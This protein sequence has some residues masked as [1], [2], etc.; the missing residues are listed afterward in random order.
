MEHLYRWKVRSNDVLLFFK[1]KRKLIF[2]A[3]PWMFILICWGA[4]EAARTRVTHNHW[5]PI[6]VPGIVLD[7]R[8]TQ[9]NMT[10]LNHGICIIPFMYPVIKPTF[11]LLW[12]GG[13]DVTFTLPFFACAHAGPLP[14]TYTSLSTFLNRVHIRVKSN[15]TSFTKPYL[16]H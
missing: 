11:A 14:G 3:C 2:I 5:G 10:F 16:I 12:V 7:P 15:T 1:K 8:D 6:L 9:T 4:N 13:L